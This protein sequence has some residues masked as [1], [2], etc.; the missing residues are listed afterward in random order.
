M[1][2]KNINKVFVFMIYTFSFLCLKLIIG[3]SINVSAAIVGDLNKDGVV[4]AKDMA[5][6]ST[7]YNK[8]NAE[9]DLNKDGIVDIY[10]ITMVASNMGQRDSV[11]AIVQKSNLALRNEADRNAPSSVEIPAFSPID[12]LNRTKGLYYV[13]YNKSGTLLK[14]YVTR[15]VDILEDTSGDDYLGNLSETY[16][17]GPYTGPETISNNEWDK[18]GKSYGPWQLSSKMGSLSAFVLW[19]KGENPAFYNALNAAML[20]DAALGSENGFGDNFDKAWVKIATDSYDEFFAVQHKYIKMSYYDTLLK[21]LKPEF[22]FT[23]M[24]NKSFT[25]RNV[26]WSMAVQHGANGAKKMIINYKDKTTIPDLITALYDE[27]SKVDIYYASYSPE[28]KQALLNR[29]TKE[30]AEALRVYGYEEQYLK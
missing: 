6:I 26:F 25:L 7:Y 5:L 20:Q 16:E 9:Y 13:R 3:T 8:N 10:D 2:R 24:L 23:S 14:G 29:F 22:D 17:V 28:V 12:I 21:Y 15:F 30:K 27:R 19:L 18:G 4:D 1:Q 11:R